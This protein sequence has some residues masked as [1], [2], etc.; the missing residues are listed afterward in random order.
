MPSRSPQFSRSAPEP[1]TVVPPRAACRSLH[2]G[3]RCILAFIGELD[4]T[5]VGQLQR[6]VDLA[7]EQGAA[8]VWADLAGTTFMDSSG[9]HCLLDAERA[10][11]RLNRRFAV[12]CERGPVRRI[13]TLTGADALIAT[14]ADRAAAHRAA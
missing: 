13:L 7:V 4:V 5:T 6:A 14:Y 8:E 1:S 11:S 9:V 3:R 10:L 12:I 2:V